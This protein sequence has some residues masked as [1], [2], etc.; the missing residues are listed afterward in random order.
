MLEGYPVA[1]LR[2]VRS[3]F[4]KMRSLSIPPVTSDTVKP[5]RVWLRPTLL[6]ALTALMIFLCWQMLAPFI[7]AF[8]WALALAI[9][10]QPLRKRL[11]MW[12][13]ATLAALLTIT[14][15]I[16]GLGI[17]AVLLSH[18]MVLESLRG[19]DAIRRM[20]DQDALADHLRSFGW[21]RLAWDWAAVELDLAKAIQQ[22]A[23]NVGGWLAP[24]VAGPFRAV[25]EI[26][27]SI[28]VLFFFLRDQ[29]QILKFLRSLLPMKQAESERLL[30]G[31]QTAIFAAVYGRLAIGCL[32]GLL[33][34]LIFWFVGLPAPVFWGCVMAIFSILPVVGAFVV[35]APAALALFFMGAWGQA[36]A[37]IAWGL[38]VIHPV[39]NILYPLLVGEKLGLHS[40]A[41][42]VAFL[43]GLVVFGP[44]GL[45]L[46][47]AIV[48]AAS[49]LLDLWQSDPFSE[50]S[51]S[52]IR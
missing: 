15:L 44:P 47:P 25:S 51:Q 36:I 13:P 27:T 26:V 16:A 4:Y 1:G 42:F 19:Q 18:Q 17:P 21:I 38:A 52:I 33:G 14:L 30:S 11:K 22:V 34:G 48:A 7:P 5:P 37:V 43:G 39:D 6:A 2:S 40:L 9:A 32:Q 24:L 41:L 23:T 20:I 31:I 10:S 12:M 3:A 50:T 49:Q 28:F 8:T 46:G 29:E 45:I 35:W